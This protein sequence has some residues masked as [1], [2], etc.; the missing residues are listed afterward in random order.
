MQSEFDPT[1]REWA[2]AY[3]DDL[4][5]CLQQEPSVYERF[6]ADTSK[7]INETIEALRRN[8]LHDGNGRDRVRRR[9]G[10]HTR[11]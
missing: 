1:L 4:R 7:Q 8:V 3:L 11:H 10:L 5:A 9:A 6:G 2:I